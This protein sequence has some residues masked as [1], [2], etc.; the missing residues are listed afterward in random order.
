MLPFM[1]NYQFVCKDCS[2]NKT[3]ENF[4]K[5]TASMFLMINFRIDDENT[6]VFVAFNQL[7]TTALANLTQQSATQTFFSRDRV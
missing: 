6:S 7:C 3:D 5:K 2:Q 4:L 1:T